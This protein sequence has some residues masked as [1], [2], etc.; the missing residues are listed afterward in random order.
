M[1]ASTFHRI[2]EEAARQRPGAV[3]ITAGSGKLSFAELDAFADEIAGAILAALTG[4]GDRDGE[5]PIVGLCLPR[6]IEAVAGVLGILKAGCAWVPLDPSYPEDRLRY[7]LEDTRAPLVLTLGRVLESSAYL[8]AADRA[9]LCLDEIAAASPSPL[10]PPADDPERTAYVVYTSGSTGRPKGV[11]GSHAALL[12]RF[13]WMWETF[14][15]AAGEVCCSK[16]ALN[17]VDSVWEM[18]G[19]LLKGVPS[20]VADEATARDP[21]Q[22][23][24]FLAEEKVTRLI[25]VPS[26]LAALIEASRATGTRLPHLRYLTS[27]GELLP[28]DLA[29]QVGELGDG[30]TLINLYGSSEMAADATCC[31]VTPAA[32]NGKIVS[33]GK[34][35]GRMRVHVLD[36]AL[37]P[38][39]AGAEGELCVS[40][41]GLAKGY[42]GRPDLT[43][44]KF[45][46]NP[47]AT[48]G[49]GEHARLFRSGDVVSLRPDGD[50]DYVGRK[51]FQIKIRGFRIEPGEVEITLAQHPAIRGCAVGAAAAA[52]GQQLAAFC[53]LAPAIVLDGALAGELRSFLLAR[54]PDYMVPSRFIPLPAL[55]LLPNGKLD[56]HSLRI[57]EDMAATPAGEPPATE[58]EQRL[59]R[60]WRAVLRQSAVGIDDDFFA[61]GGDSI[62]AFRVAAQAKADGLSLTPRDVHE[63]PTIRA[64]ATNLSTGRAI[65]AERSAPGAT[66]PLSPMQTYYFTWAKPNPNKFNVGFIARIG[67]LLD[68]ERLQ[69]ALRAVVTHHDALRL[70]F[71]RCADGGF[72]QSHI[73]PEQAFAIPVHSL[74]L[75]RASEH[76][77]FAFIRAE[78]NR[79][80]DTLDI[81][82]GPVMTL[83]QFEDPDGSNHHI[84][85]TMHEL[86]TDALSLQITLEDLRTA[87]ATL[88]QGKP[89]ALPLA[90]TPYHQWVE[91]VI[92]YARSPR[93][94]AQLDYWVEQARHAAPFPQDSTDES[95]R[96]SDIDSHDFEVLNAAEMA[97]LRSRFGGGAQSALIHATV[98]SLTV[99]ANRL[100][101]QRELIFHKVAH[102]RETCIANADPSR[103]VGWF[104]THTP[105]TLSLPEGDMADEAQ[106]A[107]AFEAVSEQYRAIPDNGIGHS[108]LRYFSS[109]PRAALLAKEDRVRTLFQYIGDVWED[110]YD[111]VFFL[112]THPS[113]MDVPDTVAAE[114]LA[115]YHLHVY[116]Y[117]SDSCFRMKL[118]YTRPNYRL[119][120][121][122]KMAEIFS[123]SIKGMLVPGKWDVPA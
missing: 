73:P 92:A 10:P 6:G 40:G 16:T 108:A 23:L 98:A 123:W 4:A 18:L 66:S 36:E 22:L 72:T 105:I 41:P 52:G 53:V 112:P 58:L 93:A 81:A 117:M 83:A 79:L 5:T 37:Q 19:G 68:E 60:I 42:L 57:S 99:T 77:Q 67:A 20:V 62:Q 1:T 101:G 29:R 25:A 43:D 27:S 12:S 121:I 28:S 26:L 120:T 115:D 113:L 88:G 34:A 94:E 46:R 84:F 51:D 103:T 7:M 111:G 97:A 15:F 90:T 102:G 38:V 100:S 106:L 65:S 63:H 39:P 24:E 21:F 8:R 45:V 107:S 61:I 122:R 109:D 11:L 31:V 110:N 30:I 75:P 49:D 82:D 3:A 87:Y 104:I 14:P 86:V 64:L 2:F 76:E 91:Q 78:V 71:T 55:P 118:F 50:L 44:E 70:R 74:V 59:A 80:H 95:A 17:F 54:L 114:N 69:A 9:I 35:L 47:Y 85:L 13:E 116:A 89:I 96:Q 56:R 33:I 48:A 119:E 32:L